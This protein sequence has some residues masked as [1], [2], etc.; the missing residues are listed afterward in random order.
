VVDELWR[1]GCSAVA[2]ELGGAPSAPHSLM[3]QRVLAAMQDVAGGW[4]L[5]AARCRQQRRLR[6]DLYDKAVAAGRALLDR[7]RVAALAAIS[8]GCRGGAVGADDDQQAA[9]PP[10]AAAA[11]SS[12]DAGDGA[13]EVLRLQQQQPQHQ[14]RARRPQ[15]GLV[16]ELRI[17]VL[18][19]AGLA[20]PGVE[21]RAL[22]APGR[23]GCSCLGCRK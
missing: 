17:E 19:L 9:P 6:E 12:Y 4:L 21:L 2:S 16:S 13:E 7:K 18:A 8:G 22:S 10:G 23:A 14:A 5:A 3:P 11:A 15:E 20:P 1:Y